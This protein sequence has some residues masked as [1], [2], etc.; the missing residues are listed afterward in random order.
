VSVTPSNPAGKDRFRTRIDARLE[1]TGGRTWMDMRPYRSA[2]HCRFE[3]VARPGGPELSV[4]EPCAFRALGSPGTLRVVRSRV[5][6]SG[7]RLRVDAT[8]AVRW[9]AWTATIDVS[10]AGGRA[11][12]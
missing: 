12:P 7:D 1:T 4:R 9:L 2:E 8:L 11:R 5:V 10:V 3:V 6:Q